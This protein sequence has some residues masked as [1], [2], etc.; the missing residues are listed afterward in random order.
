MLTMSIFGE[1]QIS[2][3]STIMIKTSRMIGRLLLVFRIWPVLL[4]IDFI[5]AR[6]R[7]I[8]ASSA[9]W[10]WRSLTGTPSPATSTTQASN[11]GKHT[12]N[13]SR[14]DLFPYNVKELQHSKT[15]M[16]LTYIDIF[17]SATFHEPTRNQPFTSSFFP[18]QPSL[19][20]VQDFCLGEN[21]AALRTPRTG[22]VRLHHGIR[23]FH[24]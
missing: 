14:C 18:R 20:K 24:H 16:I 15:H 1:C 2:I 19:Q 6:F 13:A 7:V 21:H 12:K 5:L 22:G 9:Q 3:P 11:H 8:L 23:L 10:S 17:P 4:E